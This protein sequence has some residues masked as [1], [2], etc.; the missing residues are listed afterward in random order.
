MGK[1]GVAFEMHVFATRALSN[2]T[3]RPVI[4]KLEIYLAPLLILLRWDVAWKNIHSYYQLVPK[5]I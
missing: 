5:D 3:E 2:S 1:N 4:F